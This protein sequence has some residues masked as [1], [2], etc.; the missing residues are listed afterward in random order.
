MT[1]PKQDRARHVAL[2]RAVNVGG[3]KVAMADLAAVC[4][5]L[6]WTEVQTYANSGNVRVDTPAALEAGDVADQLGAALSARYNRD[7]RVV[8]RSQ[9][10]LADAAARCDAHRH[11]TDGPKALH[12]GFCDSPPPPDAF[13]HADWDRVAPDRA[14]VSGR[15]LLLRYPDGMG[16]SKMTVQWLLRHIGRDRI[17]TVRSI[18]MVRTL[19]EL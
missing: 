7:L 18:A 19:S 5:E 11:P 6:G 1:G 15:E 12:V 2:L 13:E 14:E 4:D 3:L 17:L 16:R 9:D 10:Q 8:V